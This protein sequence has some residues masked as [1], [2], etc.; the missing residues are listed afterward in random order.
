MTDLERTFQHYMNMLAPDIALENEYRGIP[1]RKFR[2]DFAHIN[3]KVAIECQGGIYGRGKKR[4][5]HIRPAGYELDCEKAILA[6]LNGWVTLPIT[7]GM[8]ADDPMKIIGWVT[9]V[10]DMR[11][12][13]MKLQ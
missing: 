6:A 5:A 1:G 11:L 12:N 8:L 9:G 4:G 7:S 3:S 2:F 10:I 13:G